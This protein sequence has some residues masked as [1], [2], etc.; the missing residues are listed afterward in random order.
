MSDAAPAITLE[1][2]ILFG[3]SI[4]GMCFFHKKWA[5]LLAMK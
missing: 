2:Q 5:M 4:R 1:F 3:D